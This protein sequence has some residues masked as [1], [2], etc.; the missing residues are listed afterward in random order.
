MPSWRSLNVFLS[1][2][3]EI[4]SY[5]LILGL[6]QKRLQKPPKQSRHFPTIPTCFRLYKEYYYAL[7]LNPRSVKSQKW[8]TLTSLEAAA[9]TDTPWTTPDS[10][11]N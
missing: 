10:S 8:P 5:L 1:N 6:P 9:K 3:E 2:I 4:R 7:I 11:P